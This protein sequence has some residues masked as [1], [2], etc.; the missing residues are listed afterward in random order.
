VDPDGGGGDP[1]GGP[2][3]VAERVV[4][5]DRLV[6]L[7]AVPTGFEPW[8]TFERC[9]GSRRGISVTGRIA[10]GEP[11]GILDE[12]E[13]ALAGAGWGQP[14]RSSVDGRLFALH[15]EGSHGVF[16][17]NLVVGGDAV[18]VTLMLLGDD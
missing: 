4:V 3:I 8:N 10:G 11:V 5:P 12:L 6:A 13:A 17:V 2:G 1:A 9:Q 7:A 18:V 15:V 14:A 16:N